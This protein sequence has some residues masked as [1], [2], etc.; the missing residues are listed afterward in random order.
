MSVALWE[1]LKRSGAFGG[2]VRRRAKERQV[3]ALLQG[4]LP[5]VSDGTFVQLFYEIIVHR[6]S[7]PSEIAEFQHAIATGA[8]NRSR[9]IMDFFTDRSKTSLQGK[10]ED[11][12][13]DP[14]L[15]RL[16]GTDRLVTRTDWEALAQSVQI[17]S[18]A[19]TAQ[20]HSRFSFFPSAEVEVSAIASLYKGKKFIRRFMENITSQT[21]FGRSELI[22]I[23]ANSPEQEWDV[24]ESYCKVFPNIKYIRTA[25]RIGIYEAWNLG[26]AKARGKYL[27]NVNIDDLRRQDSF[28]LQ[29][30]TL[31]HLDFIDVVY[32]DVFYTFDPTLDFSQVAAFQLL[33]ELPIV[34]ANNLIA[35]NSP[36]NAPMWR[37]KLHDEVGGFDA[38]YSSAGDWEFWIRC[39]LAGK[40]F[41]KL[42]D[43]HVL[44]YVNPDGIS[45][46]PTTL[47]IVEGARITRNYGR[48]L[49]SSRLVN[50]NEDFLQEIN[51]HLGLTPA[52]PKAQRAMKD[53]RYHAAQVALRE[54]SRK[55]RA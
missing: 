21:I 53:W 52:L 37:R 8:T 24:I 41:Y 19:P 22:I 39:L 18:V 7:L 4:L 44:Y 40:K 11:R 42:N 31:N 38:E 25:E 5:R 12:R 13:H 49:I 34:C 14:S 45:T 28:E 10:S 1:A 16:V 27:T 15:I 36:H 9:M 29:A 43:P 33:S 3:N 55:A 48:K 35:Y 46:R 23:D 2:R 26:I 54:H 50:S 20:R 6:G 47:G 51:R 32:Q 17:G 30:A